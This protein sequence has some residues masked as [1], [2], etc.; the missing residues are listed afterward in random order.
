MVEPWMSAD[1]VAAHLGVANNDTIYS[2][3]AA[4]AMPAHKIGRL[5]KSQTS[6]IDAWI[7]RGGVAAPSHNEDNE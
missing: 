1:E 4:K 7:R 6:E 5:W 2:W 3:I